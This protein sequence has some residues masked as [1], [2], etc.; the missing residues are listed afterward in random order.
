[1]RKVRT[2]KLLSLI[3]MLAMAVGLFAACTEK[4]TTTT[5]STTAPTTTKATTVA[6]T[7]TEATT[8]R[9]RQD[10]PLVV[11]YSAFS[12]KFSPFFADTAYDNDVSDMT[13]V[14]LLTTDRTGAIVYNAIEG[15]T[16][17]YGGT[18]YVYK[19]LANVSVEYN[20]ATDKT[21]YT[22]TIRDDVHFSDGELLTA[23]D[24]IFTYY[25]YCDPSYTGST[26]LYSVPIVGLKDYR[27]Q[28]TSEVYDKYDALFTEIYT[29]GEDHEW[30]EGDNW[31]KEQ[32]ES[33]WALI[34]KA[35]TDDVQ[36]IV[37]YVIANYMG[38]AEQ[39]TGYKPDEI[40]PEEGL[41]IMLG[42]ALW[43]FG[44]VSEDKV[45]TGAYSEKTWNLAD[46]EYP[47]IEDYYNET[48]LAYE[49]D[50]EAY[51]GVESVAD[52]AVIDVAR[53]AFIGEWGPKDESM[54][55]KGVPNIAGV[56]KV[57]D[58]VVEVTVEGFDATAIYSLGV[59]ISPLHYYG[60]KA[61][62]DYANSKFG[63]DFGDLSMVH[64][65]TT[66]PMGAGA[67]KFI[68]YENKVVY[69]EANEFY[70]KGEP[71]ITNLQFKETNDADKISGVGT[72]TIDITDPSFS[73]A[74]IDE[75][76]SYNSNGETSGDK[77][78]T[79]TVDNLGYGYI[80]INAMTVN[81]AGDSASDASK[82]LRKGLATI[83]AAYRDLTV[84]SYY[85][86]RASVINYPISNT[87]WAA[88]QPSDDGYK[89]A[90]STAVD[91]KDIF[92][93]SMNAEQKYDAAQKAAVD[94]FVAAGYTYDE[95]SGKLT[96][97]PE[98]ASLEY[99]VIIP[100]DGQGDHPS[101]MLLTEAKEAFDKIGINL[102]ND[103][104]DSN[105]LWNALDAETQ[106]LWCAAWGSTIDPDMYQ[107]YHSNNVVGLPGSSE[108][109]HYHIQDAQLDE[110]IMAA[111]KSDDQAYRK[112]T[113]KAC[114]DI[115]IDWAVEIPIYQRQNAIIFSADRINMDT[116]TPDITTFWGWAHDIE[117]LQMNEN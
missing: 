76:K 111:R 46:K 93:S 114:L 33:F 85:G 31:T 11:G 117:L 91:G 34:K 25:T 60:D 87:S 92:T 77:I 100:A 99:E 69:F 13:A 113:Y 63:F 52:V 66:Q 88:P 115:I 55:G 27:T 105:E 107:V 62:Y 78:V 6:T 82:N 109:N 53:S 50:P 56:K 65:K 72:G 37:N 7:T 29:A 103:P 44:E 67:Y 28:T 17:P 16:I 47:T 49:G 14:G 19:G 64:A 21:V 26:T 90:F 54:G 73:T 3:L 84:D 59:N 18:D 39:Y 83:L 24:I 30:A 41:K 112:Q 102:I 23:D 48:Y 35:W 9:F 22:W 51:F 32:Q 1:M 61:K 98:G 94:Y 104:A 79:N 86:E 75:I 97:A 43:G 57:S 4:E 12:E 5:T 40:T 58:T 36:G 74:A 116:V 20:E 45:L 106:E 96:A 101:F 2:I 70:Y 38:Y 10:T 89:V 81:V 80:G 95:A 15:E 42:M 108:S 71:I 8:T 68:K 110:L